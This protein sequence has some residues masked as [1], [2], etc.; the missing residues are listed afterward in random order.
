MI[1]VAKGDKINFFFDTEF[2]EAGYTKPLVL[3]SIGMIGENSL[4]YYAQVLN[5]SWDD[6]SDWVK[7]NVITK[8]TT[9]TFA[10][11]YE[12][13]YAHVVSFIS[14]YKNGHYWSCPTPGCPWRTRDQIRL[15][16]LDFCPPSQ[17]PTFWAYFADYDWVLFCQLFGIMIEMPR[18]YPH[19]CMD[20]KQYQRHLDVKYLPPQ[21]GGGEHNALEDAKWN[22]EVWRYLDEVN[23]CRRVHGQ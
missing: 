18:G 14:E 17:S 1:S 12:D 2:I 7:E 6:A 16:L 5:A 22:L 9:C 10:D 20:L 21:R 13:R 11:V 15:D 23:R 8:F 3:L 19:L 4:E